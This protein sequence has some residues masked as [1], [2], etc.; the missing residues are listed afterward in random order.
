MSEQDIE[1]LRTIF[2][3]HLVRLKVHLGVARAVLVY[4]FQ[5][6]LVR[7][8]A[9]EHVTRLVHVVFQFH[10]VRLK[11]YAQDLRK[12]REIISIPF[13]TIKRRT[14]ARRCT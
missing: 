14:T 11:V 8:K 7:L 12:E 3:F 1:T 2:Q 9:D 4:L 13:S 10:L 6:H 5:F